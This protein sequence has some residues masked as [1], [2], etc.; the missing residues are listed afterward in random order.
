MYLLQRPEIGERCKSLTR[1]TLARASARRK[2]RRAAIYRRYD[3]SR[4]FVPE[5]A[6]PCGAV[7]A[8]AV[9]RGGKKGFAWR[10][11]SKSERLRSNKRDRQTVASRDSKYRDATCFVARWGE[12][13][14]LPKIAVYPLGIGI[15]SVTFFF[16][17][18]T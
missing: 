3:N 12:L 11:A 10:E 13:I 6:L 7:S 9:W 15:L 8:P 18:G 2:A 16:Y 1:Y 5:F 14:D 4:G 17:R